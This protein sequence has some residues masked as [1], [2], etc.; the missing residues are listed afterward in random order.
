M[1]FLQQDEDSDV[2]QEQDEE[3]ADGDEYDDPPELCDDPNDVDNDCGTGLGVGMVAAR[4]HFHPEASG[5]CSVGAPPTLEG[6]MRAHPTSNI[7]VID[8][9]GVRDLLQR[10]LPAEYG[11]ARVTDGVG[12]DDWLAGGCVG[13]HVYYGFGASDQPLAIKVFTP[14]PSVDEVAWELQARM[15][16]GMPGGVSVLDD[17][18]LPVDAAPPVLVIEMIEGHTGNAA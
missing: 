18:L 12:E 5:G 15:A 10:G 17:L 16:D 2:G 1:E 9:A 14:Q 3:D 4:H 6:L 7:R 13:H 8:T 11:E